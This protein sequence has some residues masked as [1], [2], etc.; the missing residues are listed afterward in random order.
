LVYAS[1]FL[2][3]ATPSMQGPDVMAAQQRLAGLGFDPGVAD[4][5]F[6]TQTDRALRQFQSKNGL[7]VDGVI[8]PDTWTALNVA[9]GNPS[10]RITVDTE[11]K[12]LTLRRG[13]AAYRTYPVAPGRP[14][15]PT[16]LGNWTITEKVM[17]PG[18][19]FGARWMRLS[20]PWGA[21]GIHGTD[22][23]SSIGAYASHGCVRMYN[24][25]VAEVYDL[26]TIGTPVDI[27]GRVFTGRVLREGVSPGPDV[28]Q[29][30]S[31]LA[32]LGFYS[33][34]VDGY[35][36]PQTRAAVVAFQKSQGLTADGIVGPQTYQ[37][38]QKAYDQ[39]T[40]NQQP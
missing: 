31:L 29:V 24:Q 23:P 7:I 27:I 6:G 3:L 10:A 18:G 22:N 35:F 13:N 39:A 16:P 4:G 26:V 17:N 40:G 12:T 33:G 8:G 2:R 30:Q 34:D 15:T 28:S 11:Q 38:L 32:V 9:Q 5:V 36:G 14:E 21:Y 20:I 25:D 1:R 37:A 19:P